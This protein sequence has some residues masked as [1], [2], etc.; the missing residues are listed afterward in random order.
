MP[1]KIRGLYSVVSRHD[2]IFY[3]FRYCLQNVDSSSL[4]NCLWLQFVQCSW[5]WVIKNTANG[6]D[7][8]GKIS[9]QYRLQRWSR[10][11]YQVTNHCLKLRTHVNFIPNLIQIIATFYCYLLLLPQWTSY[12]GSGQRNGG[13]RVLSSRLWVYNCW[14]LLVRP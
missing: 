11:L 9:M 7:D 6:M 5:Q 14:R 10:K 13:S 4:F 8:L 12:D 1:F 2:H 3:D